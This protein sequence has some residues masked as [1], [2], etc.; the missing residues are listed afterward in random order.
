MAGS[1][2]SPSCRR[3]EEV[4]ARLTKG[5]G[6]LLP[7]EQAFPPSPSPPSPPLPREWGPQTMRGAPPHPLGERGRLPSLLEG[8]RRRNS[9]EHGGTF[10][11]RPPPPTLL[12]RS[13]RET[14]GTKPLTMGGYIPLPPRRARLNPPPPLG[15]QEG[16]HKGFQP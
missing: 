12:S 14:A 3:R 4:L 16:A 8:G 7:G 6:I 5:E 13:P 1:S 2:C 15:A 9:S 11:P 10:P